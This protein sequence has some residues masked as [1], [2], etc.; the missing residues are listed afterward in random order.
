MHTDFIRNISMNFLYNRFIFVIEFHVVKLPSLNPLSWNCSNVWRFKQCMNVV[1]V[2]DE[3]HKHTSTCALVLFFAFGLV[4]FLGF[5]FHPV[6]FI[7]NIK[8]DEAI[9]ARRTS[10]E[11]Y[12]Y[13]NAMKRSRGLTIYQCFWQMSLNIIAFLKECRQVHQK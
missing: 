2:F 13:T 11:I 9:F 8:V 3:P 1:I 4:Q 5:F 6:H 12:V 10:G 7:L